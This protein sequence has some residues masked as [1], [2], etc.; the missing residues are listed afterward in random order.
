M[1]PWMLALS[2][3]VRLSIG[4]ACV[5][6][7]E[8]D[9]NADYFPTKLASDHATG[10]EV[11][12]Y[13]SY[14]VIDVGG[15][16]IVAY[17]C[18]T[19]VPDVDGADMTVQIPFETVIV[20]STT[21][22]PFF[23]L[24][25]YRNAI[26]AVQGTAAVSSPCLRDAIDAGV[27]A[28]IG[29]DPTTYSPSVADINATDADATFASPYTIGTLGFIKGAAIPMSENLEQTGIG[30]A[31]WLEY[32]ALF[33]NAEEAAMSHIAT[34]SGHIDNAEQAV[35]NTL[36]AGNIPRK[37]VLWV[38]LYGSTLYAGDCEHGN[39]YCEL[40]QKAGGDIVDLS[41]IED[42]DAWGGITN[43]TAFYE[44]AAQAD[45]WLYPSQNWDTQ[46]LMD[47][48]SLAQLAAV[49]NNQVYDVTKNN[50]CVGD[51]C[52]TANDFYESRMAE[53]DVLLEDLVN[54]ITPAAHPVRTA[55]PWLLQ[56][57]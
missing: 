33:L 39:Y 11:D 2:A 42:P 37:S 6:E 10:W 20:M 19:P 41:D 53:P 54:I 5:A 22:I 32:V 40:V 49:Q 56:F 16:K 25:G 52:A 36:A 46:S 48:D 51:D 44:T 38:Y 12:Y 24:L 7:G 55:N 57:S 14:K 1:K 50:R 15:T 34:V 21:Y 27:V 3:A 35:Q 18:G 13:N 31:E 47:A 26:K 8:F 23:E 4:E 9:A 28:D 17:Q 30:G 29:T 45:I 43:F